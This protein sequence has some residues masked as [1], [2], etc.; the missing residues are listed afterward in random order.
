MEPERDGDPFLEDRPWPAAVPGSDGRSERGH[1][2]VVGAAPVARDV[3]E[4]GQGGV[5]AGRRDPGGVDARAADEPDAPT[6]V[7]AGTDGGE[8]VVDNDVHGG[9]ALG[10]DGAA[11]AANVR[12]SVGAGKAIDADVRGLVVADP[13]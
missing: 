3:P 5:P 12:G 1:P 9:E 13:G 8:R 4:R 6:P 2:D 7:R 11:E 10:P